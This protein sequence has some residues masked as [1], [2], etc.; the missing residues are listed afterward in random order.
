MRDSAKA[1]IT[2]AARGALKGALVGM[3]IIG[4][5][6]VLA[7]GASIFAAGFFPG[8]VVA[9]GVFAAT[10]LSGAGLLGIGFGA[11]VGG[12]AMIGACYKGLSDFV[13]AEEVMAEKDKMV[14]LAKA[15]N[16]VAKTEP[17]HAKSY[18]SFVPEKVPEGVAEDEMPGKWAQAVKQQRA[19][20]KSEERSV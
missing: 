5:A 12:C 17:V 18:D 13:D 10:I 4:A 20:A 6:G 11:I 14:N 3:G 16:V 2:G 7:L 8:L 1:L 19:Q 15:N 9:T